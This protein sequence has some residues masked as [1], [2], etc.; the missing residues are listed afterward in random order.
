M[1]LKSDI[2][3]LTAQGRAL[4]NGAAG[5]A[6]HVMNTTSKQ[7]IDAVVTGPQAVSIRPPLNVF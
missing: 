4:D 6:I 7:V 5:D 2:I 1:L 3:S